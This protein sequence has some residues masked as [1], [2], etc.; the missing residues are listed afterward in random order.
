MLRFV[1]TSIALGL[2]TSAGVAL[3]ESKPGASPHHH[4]HSQHQGPK[5]GSKTKSKMPEKAMD[6]S[7][8]GHPDLAIPEGQPVPKIKLIVTP[9][10]M[11]GWNMQVITENFTFAPERVNSDS[12]TSEG[13]AHLFLNG[14]KIARI[15]GAWSHIPKLPQGKNEIR[16]SLNSNKHENLTHQGK[17]IEAIAIVEVP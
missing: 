7:G 2:F 12:K 11:A 10:A 14:R 17:A 13:H 15:Y 3:A 5:T 9:D 1:T 16:V 4:D 8:H 6:H